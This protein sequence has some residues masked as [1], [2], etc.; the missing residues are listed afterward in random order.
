M[1]D[2]RSKNGERAEATVRRDI[3]TIGGSAGAVEAIT[4]MARL[5]A[6]DIP[7]AIFVVIHISPSGTSVL[8]EILRRAGPLAAMHAGDGEPIYPGRIYHAPPNP[9]LRLDPNRIRL[10][11][12]PR[13]N[14]NRPAID[15]L[16]RSAARAYG[17]RVTGVILS[18]TLDDGAAGLRYIK[19]SGGLALAQEPSEAA[20]PGMP[21]AAIEAGNVDRVGTLAEIIAQIDASARAGEPPVPS[22]PG[23]PED[24]VEVPPL[25]RL[26]RADDALGYSCPDCGGTLWREGDPPVL[27]CRVGPAFSEETLAAGQAEGVEHAL[28]AAARAL[29]ER[30]SLGKRMIDRAEREDRQLMASRYREDVG[31]AQTNLSA[32]ERLLFRDGE[33]PDASG[34][35]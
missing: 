29:A 7:A 19:R 22:A 15:P 23:V 1:V 30:I 24:T 8:P 16:F 3:V 12:G 34:P 25:S 28:W 9:D 32:I 11:T 21:E 18:G 6:S 20:F 2:L 10:S 5:F 14:R 27:R 13:E 26:D 4:E 31:A 33:D 17:P 35:G